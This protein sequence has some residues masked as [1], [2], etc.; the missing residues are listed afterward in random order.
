MAR[1]GTALVVLGLLALGVG[2]LWELGLVPGSRVTVPAPIALQQPSPTPGVTTE[3]GGNLPTR[4][5]EGRGAAVIDSPRSQAEATGAGLTGQGV[6]GVRD[7]GDET[8]DDNPAG[9]LGMR[10]ADADERMAL[11]AAGS[12]LPAAV[13]GG[14]ATRLV[15]PAIQ[16]DTVV[17]Q[18]GIVPDAQ[19]EP[20]WQTLP[21]V[22]VHYGDLTARIGSRGNAVIA[23]HVVTLNE[24]NVF[25]SLYRLDF[26]DR[27]AVWD[28]QDRE[29]D[30]EVIDVKL[31]APSDTSVMAPTVDE[32]LTLITCGGTFDPRRREFSERLIVTARPVI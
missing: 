1:V 4:S 20:V 12:A 7:G 29:R 26:A 18:A 9:A 8:P 23:G 19:G 14:Y 15:I 13:A 25:R 28:D 6:V 2:G 10:A 3:P 30:F 22:A 11:S 27:I 17:Q 31:V 24:G 21:F 5:D 16:L 32:T